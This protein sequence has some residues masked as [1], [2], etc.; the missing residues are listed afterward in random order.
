M[1]FVQTLVC[2][3]LLAWTGC[4]LAKLDK[5]LPADAPLR[6]GVLHRPEKCD[7]RTQPGDKL[8]MHYTG[9]LVDGTQFDSSIGR[10]PFDFT[11]GAGMVIKGWDQGLVNMCVGEKRKLTIPSGLGYGESGAGT[12][13]AGATLLFEVEL[14]NIDR[15]SKSDL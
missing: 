13:P 9:K 14:L 8:S 12:I 11:L 1:R 7:Q 3:L 6:I 5:N 10:G 15:S 4:V 2:L